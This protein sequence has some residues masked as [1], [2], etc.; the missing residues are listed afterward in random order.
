MLRA[1]IFA[2]IAGIF[3]AA[4]S[5]LVNALRHPKWLTTRV[6]IWLI[7]GVTLA[8][9][10]A[11]VIQAGRGSRGQAIGGLPQPSPDSPRRV[12]EKLVG[13]LDP[14]MT[15]DRIRQLLG[16][17]EP[18][19]KRTLE[20]GFIAQFRREW[21]FIHVV[22]D[23]EGNSDAIAVISRDEEFRPEPLGPWPSPIGRT[24]AEFA[25][26][27]D[28]SASGLMSFCGAQRTAYVEIEGFVSSASE[29]RSMA[30][31]NLSTGN[32]DC[33]SW[34]NSM[35]CGP[36]ASNDKDFDFADCLTSTGWDSS[37]GQEF[38]R[39]TLVSAVVVTAPD[40]PITLDMLCLPEDL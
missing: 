25:Q 30:F 39:T 7:V 4:A 24:I 6:T 10:V 1:L 34:D 17:S 8:A 18:D 35:D 21:E 29:F 33:A 3:A 28:A 27:I 23:N 14:G 20:T 40:Q 12:E 9:S 15:Y 32:M 19:K 22:V 31:G 13:A 2:V 36:Q 11:A 16:N 5:W 26:E 37:S 38:R